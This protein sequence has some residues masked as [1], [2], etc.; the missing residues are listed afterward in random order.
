MKVLSQALEPA[1]GLETTL[2]VH[3][4]PREAAAPLA[5]ELTAIV[6]E[7]GA[8]P[9]IV[10]VVKGRPIAGMNPDDL[11]AMLAQKDVPK[12]NTANLGIA[13]HQGLTAATT[14]ST[15]MEIC[16][17]AG[18]PFFATGGIGGVHRGYGEHLDIS[19]DLLALARFPVA[20]VSSGVKSLLDVVSTREALESLGV[21]VVG[22]RTD[23]F[24]AFY[25][26]KSA[27][28][29]DIRIDDVEGLAAFALAELKRTGRGIL[30][31]QPVPEEEELDAEDWGRWL[32][33]AEA[34]AERE[35]A[36]GRDATPAILGAL[37]RISEGR[38]LQANLALIRE[39][40]R[41]AARLAAASIPLR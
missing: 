31:V 2:L 40:T 4:V 9:A 19:A 35:G 25:L 12:V 36:R 18:I 39:N 37:H 3:G 1:V 5:R 7:A 14:V 30:I 6:R 8:H 13:L 16:S 22:Y 29:V 26:R 34:E 21:P 10:G 24:P 28:S 17:A 20:V 27:A 33:K 15:T 38:T 23:S 32:L 11:E 41:L